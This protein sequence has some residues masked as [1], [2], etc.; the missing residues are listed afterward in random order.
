MEIIKKLLIIGIAGVFSCENKFEPPQSENSPEIIKRK[1]IELTGAEQQL[2]VQTNSFAF[3]LVKTVYA[4]E[5]AHKNILIS[6]FSASLA[7]SMLNNGSDGV[8]Q[9]EIRQ[10]LGFGDAT[11]ESIN[12]YLQKIADAAQTLDPYGVYKSANSIWIHHEFPVV[13]SFK[14]V[15]QQYYDAEIHSADFRKHAALTVIN[16]WASEKTNGKI[17]KILD[18]LDENNRLLLMSAP[19]FKGLWRHPFYRSY[20]ANEKFHA[21]TGEVQFVPTMKSVF[22]RYVKTENCSAVELPFQ[23]GA[24][25]FVI[26][27]PGED[28]DISAIVEQMDSEWWKNVTDFDKVS[29]EMF[30]ENNSS[31]VISDA[32]NLNISFLIIDI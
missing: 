6:P 16:K 5:E 22:N 13:N 9:T 30:L 31:Y 19:F 24:F 4:N 26:V 29:L 15:I 27:L 32:L 2:T 18:K 1:D 23:N 10:A 14:Q 8:T 7:F 3:N 21:S 12:Q 25:S 11:T 17:P 28:T 20:T